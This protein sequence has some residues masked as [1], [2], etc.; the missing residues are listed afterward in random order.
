MSDCWV[1]FFGAIYILVK[2]C[3]NTRNVVQ[4]E[5]HID[6]ILSVTQPKTLFLWCY[7]N[8]AFGTSM[9]RSRE[10]CVHVHLFASDSGIA[11]DGFVL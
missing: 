10:G 7:T 11:A 3:L 8:E 9:P 1:P 5:C 4:L 6:E 2:V